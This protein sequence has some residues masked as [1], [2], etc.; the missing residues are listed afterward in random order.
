MRNTI[1][2]VLVVLMILAQAIPGYARSTRHGKKHKHANTTQAAR[3]S[4]VPDPMQ[5]SG[6]T[7]TEVPIP[8]ESSLKA[9]IPKQKKVIIVPAPPPPP[10][11]DPIPP[12]REP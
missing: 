11:N 6:N 7:A 2:T 10:G 4:N 12:K 1:S 5:A 3:V 9:N 8:E